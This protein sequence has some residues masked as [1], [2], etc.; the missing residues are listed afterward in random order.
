MPP[1]IAGLN[2]AADASINW[3]LLFDVHPIFP[4]IQGATALLA[5]AVMFSSYDARA[6]EVRRAEEP[7]EGEPPRKEIFF[8]LCV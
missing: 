1:G 8:F 5:A 4:H 3:R 2:C 7:G 6:D